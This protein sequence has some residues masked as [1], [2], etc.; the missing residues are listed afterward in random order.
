MR[1]CRLG[2]GTGPKGTARSE[3][4]KGICCLWGQSHSPSLL[5]QPTQLQRG[6]RH[7]SLKV[8]ILLFPFIA[9]YLTT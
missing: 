6:W 8:V 5:T 3:S 4:S 2:K 7:I 9:A 1:T